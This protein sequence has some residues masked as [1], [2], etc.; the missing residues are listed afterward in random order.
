M[1]KITE[2]DA[3]TNETTVRDM[4]ENELT[5]YNEDQKQIAKMAKADAD[6]A[7]LKADTLSKLGLTAEEVA[8][9][10]S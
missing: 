5:Q 6:R 2:H 9:L 1:A 4:T 8:A 10:L 7:K 3:I